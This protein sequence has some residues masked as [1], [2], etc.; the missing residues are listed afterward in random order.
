MELTPEQ[1]AAIQAENDTLKRTVAELT[2]KNKTRKAKLAEVESTLADSQKHLTAAN[3]QVHQ[4]TIVAPLKQMSEQISTAPDLWLE[5]FAKGMKC[6]LIDGK[7]T[8]VSVSDGK[9]VNGKDGM[10]VEFARQG[11]EL[12]SRFVQFQISAIPI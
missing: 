6:E 12:A 8:V 2:E 9:P 7:L 4:L 1:I 5:Q 11:A 3:D 10:P